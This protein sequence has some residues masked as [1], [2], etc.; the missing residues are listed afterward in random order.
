MV[1][2]GNTFIANTRRDSSIKKM[3]KKSITTYI[4]P[5]DRNIFLDL[6][7]SP[8][9]AAVL[10]AQSKKIIQKKVSDPQTLD[11]RINFID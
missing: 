8:K 10:K 1:K 3:N 5:A 4:T 6:G 7:F 9:E 11:N 2:D